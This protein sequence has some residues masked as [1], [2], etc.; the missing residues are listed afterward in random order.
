MKRIAIWGASGHAH[1]ITNICNLL[2]VERLQFDIVGYIDDSEVDIGSELFIGKPIIKGPEI[3]DS[4]RRLDVAHCFLGF[5][6]CAKRVEKAIYLKENGINILTALHPGAVIADNSIIE[7]G[8]AALAGVVIDPDCR[9]GKYCI[10]NNNAVISHGCRIGDGVHVCPGVH[11]AGN[12]KIGNGSWIGIGSSVVDRLTI[13]RGSFIGAG[14]VV[15][16][17][18]PSSVLVYGNPARVIRVID[19]AF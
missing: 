9:I 19:N 10:I 16:R 12:V 8:S 14:S 3:A 4:L 5:G 1:V 17:D 2:N 11:I 7:E 13:G 6:H 18:V 15:T